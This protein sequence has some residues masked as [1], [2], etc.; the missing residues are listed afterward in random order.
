MSA[1]TGVAGGIGRFTW[2]QVCDHISSALLNDLRLC[3]RHARPQTS[4]NRWRPAEMSYPYL[5]G[6]KW[7]QVQILSARRRSDANFRLPKMGLKA[8]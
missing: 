3:A 4:T 6:V 1:S 2:G 7:S 5:L 8:V